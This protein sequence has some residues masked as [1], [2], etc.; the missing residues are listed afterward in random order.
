MATILTL[1]FAL[2]FLILTWPSDALANAGIPMI[3][4]AMPGMVI[5][6]IPIV[7]IE[8]W[9]LHKYLKVP[10]SRCLKVMTIANLES[11]IIGI[12]LA[13]LGMLL[14]E[15]AVAVIFMMMPDSITR[16]N[17]VF[18][19]AFASIVGAAWLAPDEKYSYW[20][21]P[22]AC[23]VLLIPFYFV[24]WWY[25]YSSVKRQ[26]KEANPTI[27][28]VA[29]RNL[30]LLSYGFLALLVFGWLIKSIVEKHI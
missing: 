24:T 6:F 28:K 14:V 20:A 11:T 18:A 19:A 4:L 2:T 22:L 29:T 9:Y 13:W 15:M 27:L 17:N 30:N 23:L 16:A 8:S 5:S 25:E 1:L 12:P 7:A 26:M 3:A 21:V 10:F